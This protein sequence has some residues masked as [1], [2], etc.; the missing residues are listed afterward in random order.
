M[1]DCVG[2]DRVRHISIMHEFVILHPSAK[3]PSLNHAALIFR[4]KSRPQTFFGGLRGPGAPPPPLRGRRVA[5]CEPSDSGASV[6]HAGRDHAQRRLRPRPHWSVSGHQIGWSSGSPNRKHL[7]RKKCNPHLTPIP[8]SRRAYPSIFFALSRV[9]RNPFEF[10]HN[11]SINHINHSS[12]P[13][14]CGLRNIFLWKKDLFFLFS[15]GGGCYFLR[16]KGSP[17]PGDGLYTIF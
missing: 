1:T 14:H 9:V 16:P 11:H 13:C 10:I 2:C 5:A 7:P 17:P 4:E 3:H 6:P 15:S 12:H 8:E